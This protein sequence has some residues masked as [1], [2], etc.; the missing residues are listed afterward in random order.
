MSLIV[1]GFG[2]R[3]ATILVKGF[4]TGIF[5]AAFK[6]ILYVYSLVTKIL[7]VESRKY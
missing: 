6:K 1:K 2:T 5:S 7:N 3:G 4:G